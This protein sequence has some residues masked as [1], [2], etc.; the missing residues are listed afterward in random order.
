M[1]SP[2]VRDVTAS[3][4]GVPLDLL[5][6]KRAVIKISHSMTGDSPDGQAWPPPD[7]TALWAIVRRAGGYTLWRAIE[8]AES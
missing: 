4:L 7:G 1:N 3:P 8:V 5:T 2:R 6:R